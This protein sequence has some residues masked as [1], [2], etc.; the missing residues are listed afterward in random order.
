MGLIG[1]GLAIQSDGKIVVV[2]SNFDPGGDGGTR[3]IAARYL[4]SGALDPTFGSGSGMIATTFSNGDGFEAVALQSDRKIVATGTTTLH[5]TGDVLVVRLLGTGALDPAYGAGTGASAPDFGGAENAAA[6]AI[7]RDGKIVVGGSGSEPGVGT[8][9]LLAA[10]F[11]V[12]DPTQ[13]GFLDTSYGLG[14]GASRPNAFAGSQAGSAVAVQPSDGK[15]LVAGDTRIGTGPRDVIVARFLSPQGTS[16]TG[17]GAGNGAAQINFGGDDA[18]NAM[19]LQPDGKVL[20]TGTTDVGGSVDFAVARL[21]SDGSPDNTFGDAGRTVIDLGGRDTSNAIALQPDGKIILAG[22]R[23]VGSATDAAVVRLQPNGL[24]DSTFGSDGKKILALGQ[25][26]SVQAVALQPNGA[27]VLAGSSHDPADPFQ[28]R[29][30]VA[31]LQGDPAG[32]PGG[33]PGGGNPGGGNPGGG[34]TRVPTC[35][36]HKATIIGTAGKDRLTGT[37][38]ADVIVGLGGNDTIKGLGGNDI[39]CAG[40]G[41]DTVAAGDGNDRVDAGNGNDHVDGG[42]GNDT[43]AGANGNDRL[44]GGNGKDRLAGGN[45]N[46]VLDG[47]AGNDTL[48]GQAG[49]DKLT[50]DA[51]T[52]PSTAARAPINSRRRR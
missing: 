12:G 10:R 29:F 8:G 42:N 1:R 46:D 48:L 2:G 17:F 51:A 18:A 11:L 47:G 31:R 23:S 34:G 43:L 45:G 4:S 15:I 26:P 25:S 14:T 21:N 44:G 27:I 36:G 49:K 9:R 39:I 3:G 37:K 22:N 41:N 50:G 40:D 7:E 38:R 35:M 33:N 6:V 28:S 52:T 5:G 16:D 32:S 24:P 20:V 19:V 13:A 30:L